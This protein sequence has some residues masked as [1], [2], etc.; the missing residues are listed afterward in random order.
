MTDT[1][2]ELLAGF[3]VGVHAILMFYLAR[4][5]E[6]DQIPSVFVSSL[7]VLREKLLTGDV[8]ESK[9]SLERKGLDLYFR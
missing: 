8:A 1:K 2:A 5:W 4:R 6:A 9:S 7:A 3:S